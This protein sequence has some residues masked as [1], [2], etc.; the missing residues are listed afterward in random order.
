MI[1]SWSIFFFYF[2]FVGNTFAQKFDANIEFGFNT[3]QIDGDLFAGYNKLGLH[4]GLAVEYALTN[5]WRIGSGLFYNALGSQ[6]EIQIGST[7]P[8]EQQK[9]QLTY[10]TVPL[11]VSYDLANNNDRGWRFAGGLQASYLINSKIQDRLDDAILEYFNELDISAALAVDYQLSSYWSIGV[12]A[13]ESI[14][15]I[16][17]N[18]KVQEINANSLRN[19]FLT[20]SF[21]RHL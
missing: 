21:K 15:L 19:R 1:R 18:N 8:E 5:E 6:K 10:V 12:K 17:N 7:T 3:A 4:G 13:S 20:F 11:M 14:T 16:F 9:I 2:L